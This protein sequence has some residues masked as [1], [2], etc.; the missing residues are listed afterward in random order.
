MTV[1]LV[2]SLPKIPYIHRIYMVLANPTYYGRLCSALLCLI[3]GGC[4]VPYCGVE[5]QHLTLTLATQ[6]STYGQCG[7]EEVCAVN[8]GLC[9]CLVVGSGNRIIRASTS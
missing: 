6:T 9:S 4:A 8:D 7:R 1:Y 3:M 5:K 2:I